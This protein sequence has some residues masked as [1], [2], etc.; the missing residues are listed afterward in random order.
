[1]IIWLF[2]IHFEDVHM[3]LK[4]ILWLLLIAFKL[5]KLINWYNH[6]DFKIIADWLYLIPL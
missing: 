2:L 5:F 1:M 4:F 6:K 3:M